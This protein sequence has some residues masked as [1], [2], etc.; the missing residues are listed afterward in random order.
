MIPLQIVV[1]PAGRPVDRR[2][3]ACQPAARAMVVLLHVAAVVVAAA[4]AE[5]GA[6]TP[7]H[8][9]MMIAID[10]MRNEQGFYGCDYMHT[11][12]MDGLAKKSLVFEHMYTGVA[13]CAPSRTILLTGRRPDTSRV[14]TI[15]PREYWRLSG[16]NFTT[17][18]QY[19][20]DEGGY[21]TLGTG[22]IFHPGGPSGGAPRW[23]GSTVPVS[24]AGSD[25]YYSWSPE[26]LPYQN[27]FEEPPQHTGPGAGAG[28]SEYSSPAIHPFFNVTDDEMAE[29]QLAANAVRLLKL[30]KTQRDAGS[31]KPFFGAFGFHRPVSSSP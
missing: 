15:S 31:K 29:G 11:P 10:D 18:P 16:G 8:D 30:V 24:P 13:V 4:A 14:W 2:S 25:S 5:P 12:R 6:A 20:K 22:K 26:C 27:A 17:L 1:K 3:R 28:G 19:F 21:L 23:P 9:V 7:R